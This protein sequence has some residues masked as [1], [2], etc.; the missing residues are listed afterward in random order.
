MIRK[1]LEENFA[2]Y[3]KLSERYAER[4][5]RKF[6]LTT[7]AQIASTPDGSYCAM[8]DSEEDLG[9]FDKIKLII[10][11]MQMLVNGAELPR[12]S[13]AAVGAYMAEALDAMTP[14][15]EAEFNRIIDMDKEDG[16]EE[17]GSGQNSGSEADQ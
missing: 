17:D 4:L 5:M 15:L 7:V 2:S 1:N 16:G 11:G 13:R 9:L 12:G 6:D 14:E 8:F 3:M 10:K